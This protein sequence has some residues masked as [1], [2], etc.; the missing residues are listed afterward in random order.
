MIPRRVQGSR[1]T[2]IGST[3]EARSAG[4]SEDAIETDTTVPTTT[5]IVMASHGEAPY[6]VPWELMGVSRGIWH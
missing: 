4:M 2:P 1:N 6:S 5:A 3:R